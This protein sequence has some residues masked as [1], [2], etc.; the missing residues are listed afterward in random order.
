MKGARWLVWPA[1]LLS[2]MAEPAV[3]AD[4]QSP[5]QQSSEQ[6]PA[7]QQFSDEEQSG[8]DAPMDSEALDALHL[9]AETLAQAQGFS[10]TIRAGFDVVQDNGQKITFGERRKVTLIRPDRLRIDAEESDGK[11]SLVTYDG[12]V[13]TV[14]NANDNVY[15][16]VEKIGS[17]DDVVRYVVQDL[18][19]RLPLA[20]LLVSTL[21]AELDQR[22]ESIDFVERDVLTEV[23]SDHLAGRSAGVD[24]EVWLDSGGTHL[25]QRVAITYRD[26]EGAPQYRAEFSEW[27]LNPE[28]LPVDLAFNPPAGAE[29]IPFLVRV[30]Q[31]AADQPATAGE[32]PAGEAPAIDAPATSAQSGSMEGLPK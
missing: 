18:D 12:K 24:F 29:R 22:L 26:E 16:Q 1:L 5:E 25:P 15:G 14:F 3:S 17:V 6:Q 28:V 27:K 13:I 2:L 19:I 8:D 30:R 21:P 31:H 9:M 11:R 10:V 32:T 4:Q 7:D 23:P 20:L